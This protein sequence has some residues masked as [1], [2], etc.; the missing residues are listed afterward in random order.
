MMA[1]MD[2]APTL[3]MWP[4]VYT[5]IQIHAKIWSHPLHSVWVRV[6]VRTGVR[7]RVRVTHT[8]TYTYT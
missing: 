7:V 8:Y 1:N 5:H 2:T 4:K 3:L 6:R